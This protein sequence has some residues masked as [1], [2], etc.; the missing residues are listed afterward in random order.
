MRKT[1]VYFKYLD[2]PITEKSCSIYLSLSLSLSDQRVI[3][4]PRYIWPESD[5]PTKHRSTKIYL[6]LSQIKWSEVLHLVKT[7]SLEDPHFLFGF[8]DRELQ[9]FA[10]SFHPLPPAGRW[11][12]VPALPKAGDNDG[13]Q[14]VRISPSASHLDPWGARC[15]RPTRAVFFPI[16]TISEAFVQKIQG[17]FWKPPLGTCRVQRGENNVCSFSPCRRQGQKES[18]SLLDPEKQ[19]G[20][21]LGVTAN[22]VT[23]GWCVHE[24]S[25]TL[26]Q[27]PELNI[28]PGCCQLSSVTWTLRGSSHSQ[29]PF[30]LL[31]GMSATAT[32]TGSIPAPSWRLVTLSQHLPCSSMQTAA[33]SRSCLAWWL[34]PSGIYLTQL[35][36]SR[37]VFRL[38][39][40]QVFLCQEGGGIT[41]PWAMSPWNSSLLLKSPYLRN[42]SEIYYRKP[43][44]CTNLSENWMLEKAQMTRENKYTRK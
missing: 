13:Q 28:G 16:T 10:F 25:T 9:L 39:E 12:L 43:Q 20:G 22:R 26:V 36:H 8:K 38:L 7:K 30:L 23:W 3:H 19:S 41:S 29:H 27:I 17:G 11:Q 15:S 40:P 1:Y 18:C 2:Q 6:K 5:T 14:R 42:C 21:F 44:F 33:Q 24:L 37:E 4:P 34:F 35:G 31:P 32:H